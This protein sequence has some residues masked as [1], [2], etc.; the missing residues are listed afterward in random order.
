ME[1]KLQWEH[2]KLWMKWWILL[3]IYGGMKNS[4]IY[5]IMNWIHDLTTSRL[6]TMFGHPILEF[7]GIRRSL[8]HLNHYFIILWTSDGK[9]ISLVKSF[10]QIQNL[11]YILSVHIS[12][13][14]LYIFLLR[15]K[16]IPL[17]C[18]EDIWHSSWLML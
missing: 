10:I 7:C 1:V 14:P 15:Q 5:P 3:Y 16:D 11:L 9:I 17:F 2:L 6:G 13:N 4:W 18:F 8:W 12:I